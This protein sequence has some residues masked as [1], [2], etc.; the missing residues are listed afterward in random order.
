MDIDV[1]NTINFNDFEYDARVE[2]DD[3]KECE[4]DRHSRWETDDS[5]SMWQD[6][7]GSRSQYMNPPE[8]WTRL[9]LDDEVIMV[10]T[11]GKVKAYGDIFAYSSEGLSYAG[12][13]Y[14]FHRVGGKNY[15]IH[16]LVWFAFCGGVP[17]GY[18]VRHNAHYVQHRP[19][20]F[21]CNRLECLT[22]VPSNIT[23]IGSIGSCLTRYIHIL[24]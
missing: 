4:H 16:D 21:Y 6:D 23:K 2:Y 13:P 17:E 8:K 10:S 22:I 1:T 20:R 14:R 18:E 19:H 24:S 15:F 9:K 11:T 12:T 7:R 3:P 5:D